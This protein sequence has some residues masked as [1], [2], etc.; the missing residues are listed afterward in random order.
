MM[1]SPD[2]VRAGLLAA[3]ERLA[4]APS[5][6]VIGGKARQL[7]AVRPT[8]QAGGRRKRSACGTPARELFPNTTSEPGAVFEAV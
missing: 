3:H 7:S 2:E 1:Q 6:M 8:W 4:A 5:V